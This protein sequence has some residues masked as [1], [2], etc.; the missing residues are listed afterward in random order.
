MPSNAIAGRSSIVDFFQAELQT[1]TG[2][3]N[4]LC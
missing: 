1:K 4:T 3:A 2:A